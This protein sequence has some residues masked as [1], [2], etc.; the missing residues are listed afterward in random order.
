MRVTR[1]VPTWRRWLDPLA[2]QSTE[3]VARV[4]ALRMDRNTGRLR[5]VS[6]FMMV[7]QIVAMIVTPWVAIGNPAL[8]TYARLSNYPHFASF[9]MGL[10]IFA[11]AYGTGPFF[12][13]LKPHLAT[14]SIV[15]GSVVGVGLAL[16]SQWDRGGTGDLMLASMG[17][18]LVML[19]GSRATY[20]PLLTTLLPLALL[21][22]LT[23][24]DPAELVNAFLNA[25]TAVVLQVLAFRLTHGAIVREAR[26]KLALET[27]TEKLA[28]SESSL[29]ALNAQLEQRV[30]DQVGELRTYTKEV[31]RLNAALQLRVRDSAIAL[32]D[33]LARLG[34]STEAKEGTV[35]DDRF[36]LRRRI[37]AGAMGVVWEGYDREL[38]T[39]VAVKL[40]DASIARDPD[41]VQR[42]IREALAA[43][44]VSHPGIVRT[45]HVAWST[46]GQLFQ[47]QELVRGVSLESAIAPDGRLP[48]P[49]SAAIAAAVC[50]AL[51]AAHDKGVTHRDVKPSNIMI[52]VDT[53][54]VFLLDFGVAKVHE[55]PAGFATATRSG[56]V[57]GTPAYLAPEAV[58]DAANVGPATD[59]YAL[60]VLVFRLV[61]GRLPFDRATLA[62][63]LAA[64]TLEP[65]PDLAALGVSPALAALLER[66]L[67]KDPARRPTASE[68]RA[69][70][71]AIAGP[72]SVRDAVAGLQGESRERETLAG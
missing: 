62:A 66:M 29:A 36:E 68:A 28:R 40:L 46:S 11:T 53:G 67:A 65:I 10:L 48:E 71:G 3:V 32:A 42:F 43:A 5:G 69:A 45:E 12:A 9:P 54:R 15:Y 18:A 50:D 57:V 72:T 20:L 21:L 61:T 51:A 37:G 26:A 49:A 56:V 8:D 44:S 6:P 58:T 63:V 27:E 33:A 25:T 19:P 22:P 35:L 70:L 2:G 1:D 60:G 38:D 4:A 52:S 23:P 39:L 30:A 59:V 41:H 64:H 47:V 34:E 14:M 17:V 55:A 16:A 7:L 13:R 31:E 24:A